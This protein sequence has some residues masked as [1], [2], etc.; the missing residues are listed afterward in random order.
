MGRT[1][2]MSWRETILLDLY[3]V[4]LGHLVGGE[5]LPHLDS[6]DALAAQGLLRADASTVN[7]AE[8]PI[9]H[10][11]QLST[12]PLP[13]FLCEGIETGHKALAGKVRMLDRRKIRERNSKL[14]VD[15]GSRTNPS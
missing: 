3:L 10:L 15:W 14:T 8:L 4:I 1:S 5:R 13:F 6:D 12:L 7:V 9:G 11:Q 2:R